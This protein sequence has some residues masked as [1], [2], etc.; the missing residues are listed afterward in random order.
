M[1][2]LFMKC[3]LIMLLAVLL[4]SFGAVQAA[5][6]TGI[7]VYDK[8][9]AQVIV[10][11][12]SVPVGHA[13]EIQFSIAN[14]TL[15]SGFSL[16]LVFKSVD[17]GLTLTWDAQTGGLGTSEAFTVNTGSRMHP[18]D[19][20][21]DIFN[22]TEKSLGGDLPD[23]IMPG[24]ASAFSSGVPIGAYEHFYSYHVTTGGVDVGETKTLCIDT[25]F[26]PPGGEFL[27]VAASGFTYETQWGGEY[28]IN[29]TNG[30][31]VEGD[32]PAV[33]AS[34]GLNQN[35]PNPF[36]PTTTIRY[37]LERKGL[38]NISIYNILGQKVNTLVNEEQEADA[39]EAVWNGDDE[40]GTPVASGIYF[41]K[42]IAGEFVET[43][44]MVLMR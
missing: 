10:N 43:Q 4:V 17:A 16:P 9:D 42:M 1:E 23:S 2:A 12:G 18:V 27:F 39:Y 35:Y 8:D 41:Y 5:D 30:T 25:G 29:V 14:D 6:S 3:K 36:N 7:V 32:N 26:I 13:L 38:V 40:N 20:V 28:C 31:A 34:Y 11:G 15:L 22:V 19:D 37:S 24:G 33:P 21:M 44:K